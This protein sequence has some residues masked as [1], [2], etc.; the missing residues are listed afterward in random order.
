MKRLSPFTPLALVAAV[1]LLT[2][3][4]RQANNQQPEKTAPVE[5]RWQGTGSGYE[6]T[7]PVQADES[8]PAEPA[9]ANVPEA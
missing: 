8:S 1:P 4:D 9:T 7:T 3:C 6:A 2:G 5:I